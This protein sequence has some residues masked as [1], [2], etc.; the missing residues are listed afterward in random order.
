MRLGALLLVVP[1]AFPALA[2]ADGAFPD[3]LQVFLPADHPAR[4][5]L[6]ANFGL[7]E[8][9]DDGQSWYYVCEAQAGAAGN[10]S[11]Y[12]FGPTDTLLADAPQSLLRS[13][14]LG[15]TWAPATGCFSSG[16]VWDTAFDPVTAGN[17]LALSNVDGGTASGIYPSTNAA[18]SFGCPVYTTASSLS[19]IEYCTSQPGTV[20]ATGNE[21]NDAGVIGVPFLLQGFD[22]GATWSSELPHP[23]LATLLSGYGAPDGGSPDAGPPANPLIRLAEVDPNDCGTAYLRLTVVLADAAQDYLA[24][25]HDSGRTIQILFRAPDLITAFLVGA[26][27]TLYAGMRSAGLWAAPPA[28]AGLPTFQQVAGIH[29]RCLGQ[30]AGQLYACGDNW[31]DHFALGVSGDDGKSWTSLLQFVQIAGLAACPDTDIVA[32]CGRTWCGENGLVGLFGIQDAGYP[33]DA[34]TVGGG[35]DAGQASPSPRGCGC[36][37]TGDLAWIAF[38]ALAALLGWRRRCEA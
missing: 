38:A 26:D 31:A 20:Y 11:L 9:E 10:I 33:C 22:G 28:G 35:S 17:A 15:C 2:R 3:E 19:G 32:T 1:L 12:Q 36:A 6:A 37:S 24:V 18:A 13:T 14:D 23:E 27:G 30:R 4:L 34:G 16:Y 21:A 25:T 8:S 29:V 5:V 7:L